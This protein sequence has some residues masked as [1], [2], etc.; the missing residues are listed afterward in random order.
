MFFAYVFGPEWQDIKYFC[1]IQKAMSH[2][3]Q[4]AVPRNYIDFYPILIGYKEN[5]GMLCECDVWKIRRED[6]STVIHTTPEQESNR[7]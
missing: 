2:L 3:K 5:Q 4:D 7:T 6:Y 1:D